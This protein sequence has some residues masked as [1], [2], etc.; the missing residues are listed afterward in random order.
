MTRRQKCG[1]TQADWYI[2]DFIGRGSAVGSSGT[3][4]FRWGYQDDLVQAGRHESLLVRTIRDVAM[5][6]HRLGRCITFRQHRDQRDLAPLQTDRAT[7]HV[8]GTDSRVC[9]SRIQT[10]PCVVDLE[11][12]MRR[13]MTATV[14]SIP[15]ATPVPPPI[16]VVTIPISR[17]SSWRWT[18]AP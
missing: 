5:P 8:K 6:Q 18:S 1:C 2:V 12:A 14:V 15:V 16:V 9:A 7:T 10:L 17:S 4:V 3:T 13:S 11:V